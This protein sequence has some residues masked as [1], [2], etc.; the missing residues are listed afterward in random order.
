MPKLNNDNWVYDEDNT[1]HARKAS[2]VLRR[3]KAVR[4]G[5][6]Y[7]YIIVNEHPLTILEKEDESGE[8]IY[9][10]RHK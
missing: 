8:Y 5:K 10:R 2:D 9:D 3:A 6:K 4:A 7:I 1:S